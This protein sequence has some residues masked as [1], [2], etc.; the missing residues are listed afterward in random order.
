MKKVFQIVST[1]VRGIS[2]VVHGAAHQVGIRVKKIH[3]HCFVGTWVMFGGVVI[4]KLS[5]GY[6]GFIAVVIDAAGYT[7]HAIGAVPL[8]GI[9][10]KKLK[11]EE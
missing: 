3:V 9:V 8:V 10:V 6:S 5:H 11:I 2:C 7:V 1:P 4:A